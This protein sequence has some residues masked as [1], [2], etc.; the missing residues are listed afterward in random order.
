M[1][2]LPLL[3]IGIALVS[4]L[5]L[6]A[7][8][9]PLDSGERTHVSLLQAAEPPP[10]ASERVDTF[11]LFAASGPGAFGMPGTDARGYTFDDYPGCTAA[12]WTGIDAQVHR[13]LDGFVELGLGIRLDQFHGV[14]ERE[15][16]LAFKGLSQYIF[17]RFCEDLKGYKYINITDDSG[18][19]SL[20]AVKESYRPLRLIP[21]FIAAR[22]NG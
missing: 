15:V 4:L 6:S 17:R 11:W 14:I 7:M 16:R 10:F 5:A 8:A 13:D 18:L 20:K 3:G 22:E 12:G 1:R 2:K 19:E 9:R 21:A